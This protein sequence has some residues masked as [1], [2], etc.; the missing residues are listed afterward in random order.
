[1][2]KLKK[3]S[4]GILLA[5]QLVNVLKAIALDSEAEDGNKLRAIELIIQ[6]IDDLPDLLDKLPE[7]ADLSDKQP[8]GETDNE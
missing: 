2:T 1:M 7:L 8:E 5:A 6:L 4:E 3:K